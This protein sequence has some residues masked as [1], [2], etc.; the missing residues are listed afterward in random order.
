[1]K[2]ISLE[3][4]IFTAGSVGIS[5][6]NMACGIL[7]LIY[8]DAES[9][10]RFA[11]LLVLMALGQ[12]ISNAIFSS[13]MLAS[14]YVEKVSSKLALLNILFSVSWAFFVSLLIFDVVDYIEYLSTLLAVFLFLLRWFGRSV[15]LNAQDAK[16]A[17]ISDFLYGVSL[18]T[19]F[20]SFSFISSFSLECYL[21]ASIVSALLPCYQLRKSIFILRSIRNGGKLLII[22][23]LR[24]GKHALLGVVCSEAIANGHSYFVSIV[25]GPAAFAPLAAASLLF[26]PYNLLSNSLAQYER[27]KYRRT[28]GDLDGFTARFSKILA[29]ILFVNGMV[30]VCLI[31]YFSD[32]VILKKSENFHIDL[33]M[34]TFFVGLIALVNVLKLPISTML[35]A[36]AN[37][38]MVG[39]AIFFGAIV[40]MPVTIVTAISIGPSASMLGVLSGEIVSLLMILK[41][42]NG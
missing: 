1:M 9:Y 38:K 16:N 35:Q 42:K 33:M 37:F 4:F 22:N 15:R 41:K 23:Y 32:Y 27:V 29:L 6:S 7:L 34:A 36:K 17:A 26:R 10:G 31:Y 21:Y 3:R 28:E 14:K 25:F 39:S 30:V 8:A 12:G 11:L 24:H 2:A 13:A 19:F 18:V 5:L 20:L 40:A